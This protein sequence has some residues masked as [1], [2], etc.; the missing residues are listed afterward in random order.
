VEFGLD[1]IIPLGL[2]MNEAISN[3]LKHAF[4][5][6]SE[7]EIKLSLKRIK[8][9]TGETAYMLTIKDNG[10]G[11]P[12]EFDPEGVT[13]SSLGLTLIHSLASQLDGSVNIINKIGTEIQVYFKEP[14]KA[15]V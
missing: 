4:P 14:V 15:K 3:S 7:G 2:I 10:K 13:V 12:E 1:T 9:N 8:D 6:D 5:D 11:M